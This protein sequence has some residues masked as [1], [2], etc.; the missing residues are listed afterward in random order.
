M[1][2]RLLRFSTVENRLQGVALP[3]R[4]LARRQ[5]PASPLRLRRSDPARLDQRRIQAGEIDVPE[6]SF[7]D[8]QHFET[9]ALAVS[10][11]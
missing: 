9:A 5:S 1:G 3:S 6:I 4:S 7:V 8:S 2:F 11:Q 10:G